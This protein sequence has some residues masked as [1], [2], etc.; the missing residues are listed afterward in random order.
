MMGA[1]GLGVGL[2]ATSA[3]HWSPLDL[4][5][6]LL[7]LWDAENPASI[8]LSGSAVA[9]WS[10]LRHGYAASQAQP[11]ARPL[12]APDSFNGRPGISFDGIDDE[13]TFTG[14]NI[15]PLGNTPGEIWLL[16]DQQ[17]TPAETGTRIAVAYGGATTADRRGISRLTSAGS[18]RASGTVGNGASIA[19]VN[20]PSAVEYL[21]PHVVRL[22][23]GDLESQAHIDGLA[24]IPAPV[25]PATVFQ[26]L[27]FA[28]TSS[29]APA[30]YFK[31]VFSMVAFTSILSAQQSA[32]MLATANR[33]LALA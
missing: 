31:G 22:I 24:G 30:A 28:A 19:A 5:P 8:A 2:S 17:H 25:T 12:F 4:G 15:L 13:L 26:R 18:N 20:A 27:R 29:T 7:D 9:S 21:G 3:R 14:P 6:A 1:L 11:A 33:R 16:A 10:S 32:Q 23:V